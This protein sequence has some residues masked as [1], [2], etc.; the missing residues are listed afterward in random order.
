V[1]LSETRA[2]GV[3]AY[4]DRGRCVRGADENNAVVLVG[5][6]EEG[7]GE[8][9][10]CLVTHPQVDESRW[11]QGYVVLD[12]VCRDYHRRFPDSTECVDAH[13]APIP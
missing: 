11:L 9:C 1:A 3:C 6:C 8:S 13:W 4:A 2:F 12:S 5:F 10:A 7:Y